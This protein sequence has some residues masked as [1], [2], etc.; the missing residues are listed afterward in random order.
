[1]KLP[2]ATKIRNAEIMEFALIAN[3]A[4][5]RM[6][7]AEV[8][9]VNSKLTMCLQNVAKI[10]IKKIIHLKILQLLILQLPFLLKLL[11]FLKS[12]T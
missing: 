6:E 8:E 5:T 2:V 12:Q 7:Q 11:N 3:A 10:V 1:L 4:L 9:K